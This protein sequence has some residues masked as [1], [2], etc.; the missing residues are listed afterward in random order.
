MQTYFFLEKYVTQKTLLQ[1]LRERD[2]FHGSIT[3]LNVILKNIGFKYKKDDPRR[4]LMEL[5]NIALAR[6][7]FLQEYV[8]NLQ[9]ESG[10]QC[11][12]LD[13]TW[14]FENGTTCRSWQD[15]DIQSVRKVK[16]EGRR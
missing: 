6:I 15:N 8:K 10:R 11:V 4:G 2:I 9:S 7:H 16:P 12:F 3:S 1:L 13:E 14:V 5:P